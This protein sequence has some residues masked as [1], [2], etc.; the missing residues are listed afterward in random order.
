MISLRIGGIIAAA[1]IIS[2]LAAGL[3]AD[4]VPVKSTSKG[5]KARLNSE[6][7]ESGIFTI[8]VILASEEKNGK[9]EGDQGSIAGISIRQFTLETIC[10]EFG[11]C[12]ERPVF[13]SNVVT[14]VGNFTIPIPP[15]AFAATTQPKSATLTLQVEGF[16]LVSQIDKT[17]SV[18]LEWKG[19]G[20][21][22]H[23]TEV[24]RIPLLG[25]CILTAKTTG[26]E[27]LSTV[28]G[29]VKLDGAIMPI[30]PEAQGAL[31]GENAFTR[32]SGC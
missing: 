27:R 24:Q 14:S 11:E 4:A 22:S 8:I 7:Q 26:S 2:A 18:D 16:D 12:A 28:E 20:K 1:F 3:Y 6:T 21:T 30:S 13:L 19:T 9:S 29:T 5:V 10:D 23:G 31:F 32:I 17:I 15:D 25:G